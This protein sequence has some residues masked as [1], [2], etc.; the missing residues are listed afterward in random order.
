MK[1]LIDTQI[2]V[3]GKVWII[4][5]TGAVVDGKVYLHLRSTTE[6]RQAKNGKH[7]RQICDWFDI[8][9]FNK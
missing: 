5:N 3:D 7:W 6:F 2:E 9:Q 4:I 8:D 1:H